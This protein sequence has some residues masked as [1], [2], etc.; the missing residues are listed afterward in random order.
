MK[1]GVGSTYT[2]IG[3]LTNGDSEKFVGVFG[4]VVK[5]VLTKCVG[6][7]YNFIM[8]NKKR[9][10][11]HLT[12]EQITKLKQLSDETGSSVAELIRR[13]ITAMLNR[14]EVANG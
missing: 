11:Y 10:N 14:V 12:V 2:R 8:E 4:L 5:K 3:R 7:L 9:V 6:W 13:A 1:M